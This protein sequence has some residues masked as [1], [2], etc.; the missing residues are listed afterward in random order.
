MIHFLYIVS[1]L[2]VL[3]HIACLHH[4][5]KYNISE[6]KKGEDM[7]IAFEKPN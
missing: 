1:K 2:T 6:T 3:M 5:M 4:I 7:A